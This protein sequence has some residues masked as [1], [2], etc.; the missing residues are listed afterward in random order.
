M[1][2]DDE[3]EESNHRNWSGTAPRLTKSKR[4]VSPYRQPSRGG[5]ADKNTRACIFSGKLDVFLIWDGQFSPHY[6]G[7]VR[8][9]PTG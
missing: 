9:M 2:G 3:K 8:L 1:E 6:V 7:C 5:L 4:A